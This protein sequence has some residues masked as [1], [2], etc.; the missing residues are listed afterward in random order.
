M[1]CSICDK[2][3]PDDLYGVKGNRWICPDCFKEILDRLE[4][5]NK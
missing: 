5:E 3:I 2:E 1:K 4:K